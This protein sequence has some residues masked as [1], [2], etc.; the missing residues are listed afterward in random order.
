MKTGCAGKP[1][2][3]SY[4]RHFRQV[5]NGVV[6][7]GQKT[8]SRRV[9]RRISLKTPPLPQPSPPEEVFFVE[10]RLPRVAF[11]PPSFVNHLRQKRYGGQESA[12]AVAKNAAEGRHL[13][14]LV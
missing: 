1:L 13:P 6:F 5:G 3:G 8:W 14:G 11:V 10:G 12:A 2:S 7:D 4:L 9:G